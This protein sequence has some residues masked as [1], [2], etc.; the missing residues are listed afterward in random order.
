MLQ[1]PA[2]PVWVLMPGTMEDSMVEARVIGCWVMTGE[3]AL[4]TERRHIDM[5][6]VTSSSCRISR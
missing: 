2:Y 3:G 6:R 4:L 5:L 1:Q